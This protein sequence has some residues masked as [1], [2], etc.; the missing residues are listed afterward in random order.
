M[1]GHGALCSRPLSPLPQVSTVWTDL[2]ER[3]GKQALRE[4]SML[5]AAL[6]R[7]HLRNPLNTSALALALASARTAAET[8]I[9]DDFFGVS[10]RWV[11]RR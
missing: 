7:A 5:H 4:A 8:R 10:T 6:V 3:N 11:T 9:K 2:Y 1:R